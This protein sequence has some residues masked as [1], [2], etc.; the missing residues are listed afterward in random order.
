MSVLVYYVSGFF[1]DV[2]LSNLLS[3][4]INGYPLKRMVAASGI[5]SSSS[6][7]TYITITPLCFFLNS[8]NGDCPSLFDTIPGIITFLPSSIDGRSAKE[9]KSKDLPSFETPYSASYFSF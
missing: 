8:I 7:S 6:L 5:F 3:S 4:V 2:Y 9:V 1:K